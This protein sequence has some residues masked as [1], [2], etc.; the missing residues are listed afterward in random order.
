MHRREELE[1]TLPA[2]SKIADAYNAAIRRVAEREAAA[3]T[4]SLRGT[5]LKN[6]SDSKAQNRLGVTYARFCLTDKA[7]AEFGR[8]LRRGEYAPALIN[9]GLIQLQAGNAQKALEY[10]TRAQRKDPSNATL[11]AGIARAQSSLGNTKAAADAIEA[12]KKVSP[13]AAE[14]YAFLARPDQN[15]SRAASAE[16]EA[17]AWVE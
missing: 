15:K 14:R 3:F 12:L 8:I 6:P 13:E 2:E 11:L 16:E 10:F 7:A 5:L 4:D 9:L 1:V 17:V